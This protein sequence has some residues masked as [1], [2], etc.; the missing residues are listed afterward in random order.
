MITLE[1]VSV[2]SSTPQH[3]GKLCSHTWL[4]V[5]GCERVELARYSPEFGLT[6]ETADRKWGN[7]VDLGYSR[8]VQIDNAQDVKETLGKIE[9]LKKLPRHQTNFSSLGLF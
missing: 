3:A 1:R 5:D 4:K 8:I 2:Y 9:E 7:P 6:F